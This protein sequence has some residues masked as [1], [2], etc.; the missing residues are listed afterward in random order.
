MVIKIANGFICTS[1]F[2]ILCNV[3][4]EIAVRVIAG[5]DYSPLTPEFIAL[6]PSVTVAFG[7]DMLLY[8]VIGMAFSG[9]T[10]IYEIDRLGFLVQNLIYAAATGVV[11]LP[12]ITFLWQLYRYP[13]AMICTII[14]FV[15]TNIIMMVVGYQT[16]KKNIAELNAALKAKSC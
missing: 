3:I 1:F 12:I 9:F 5:F 6:F 10:F 11:W 16:T 15:I 7:V 4:I 14:G 2:G 13:E 8:G